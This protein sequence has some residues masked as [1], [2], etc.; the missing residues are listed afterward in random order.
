[1]EVD[2]KKDIAAKNNYFY[3]SIKQKKVISFG[4]V[5]EMFQ[6]DFSFTHP[7]RLVL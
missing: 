3:Q 5:K 6:Q 7:K 4:C 2:I 1:M